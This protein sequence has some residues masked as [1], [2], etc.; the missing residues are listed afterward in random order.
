MAQ[1]AEHRLDHL[2]KRN[3]LLP[4]LHACLDKLHASEQEFIRRVYE[5][6]ESLQ[7]LAAARGQA[8]QTLY[9]R[10]SRVRRLLLDCI[11]QRLAAE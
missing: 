8:L 5:R 10:L 3:D 9:N 1:I 6:H 7:E 4:A 11:Q 2:Q